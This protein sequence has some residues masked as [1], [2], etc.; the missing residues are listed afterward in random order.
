MVGPVEPLVTRRR[1]REMEEEASRPRRGGRERKPKRFADEMVGGDGA[2]VPGFPTGKRKG[3]EPA[4]KESKIRTVIVGPSPAAPKK[5]KGKAPKVVIV[6]GGYAGVSAARQLEDLGYDVLILEARDRLGGRVHSMVTKGITIELGAA[7]LMG[8]QG[9]NPLATQCRKYGVKMRVID[10]SCPLHD[11]DGSLLPPDTDQRAEQLFNKLL[12]DATE[13]RGSTSIGNDPPVGTRLLLRSQKTPEKQ[14]NVRIVDKRGRKLK[15]HYDGWN[16]RFDEWLRIPSPRLEPLPSDALTLEQVLAQQL[17]KQSTEL[18]TQGV[19]ALHWHLANLEFACAASLRT[20]S[21]EHWDQDDANEFDGDHVVMPEGGYGELLNRIGRG[22]RVRYRVAVKSVEWSA[23]DGPRIVTEQD[24][25]EAS[26]SADAV[27]VTVPLG[28]LQR[29]PKKGGIAFDPPLPDVKI[30]AMNRLGFGVLN[31]VV[32]FWPSDQIFWQHTTDFFG[33][34]VKHPSDRGLFFLF[35]N[36]F[37][38]SG[39]ACLIALAAGKSAAGLEELSDEDCGAEAMLALESMFGEDQV[40]DPERVIVTRWGDDP[41]AR[42]SYSFMQVGSSGSDYAEL[43][44]PL[45]KT[46]YFGGEH[47]N[48]LH[49]A[50]VVGAHLSGL[51]A[52]REIHR[53][54]KHSLG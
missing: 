8:V 16:S 15:L 44:K 52:A 17:H 1:Q 4:S 12:D 26:F 47:T 43:A 25:Q 6:G 48:E 45:G 32:L 13:E 34:T 23:G 9:G 35:C 42:G 29:P 19:R 36:W 2:P 14:W 38:D 22:L 11:T 53:D 33:R 37:R 54:F 21:A 18:D 20:V 50:T 27:L 28:I 51:R 10:N 40:P 46:L 24:G 49:P 5:A 30:E 7:V 41:Y 31:K 3:K 39:H